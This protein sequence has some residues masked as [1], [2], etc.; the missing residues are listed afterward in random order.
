ERQRADS[1]RGATADILEN[2]ETPDSLHRAM[3]ADP[4][5]YLTFKGK[6]IGVTADQ[7]NATAQLHD[8][9]MQLLGG[10]HDQASYDRAKQEA[11][12]LYGNSGLDVSALNLPD[13]YDPKSIRDLQLQ[14]MDTSK[15]LE[16]IA[17]ENRLHVYSSNV[18][19][20]N[21]RADRN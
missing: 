8:N 13:A 2:G 20:D 19:A 21:A 5:G 11:A 3:T 6:Q 10:V 1:L 18:A 14:G 9:V 15:Q 16:A 12:A 4:T 17:R 7:L